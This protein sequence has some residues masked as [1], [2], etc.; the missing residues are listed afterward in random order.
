M[1]I[2]RLGLVPRS[3]AHAVVCHVLGGG[4]TSRSRPDHKGAWGDV[5]VSRRRAVVAQTSRVVTDDAVTAASTVNAVR[6]VT[7]VS[8]VTGAQVDAASA[9]CTAPTA[10]AASAMPS[11]MPSAT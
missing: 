11:A 5:P 6:D 8:S 3:R 10:S 1:A 4:C 9:V 7:P 2:P